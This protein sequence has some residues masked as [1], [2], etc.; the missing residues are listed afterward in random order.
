MHIG[1]I[2][3]GLMG[4][5]VAYYLAE[6][7][8]QVTVLEQG[9]ELGGLN[10]ELR[11]EDGLS[12]ARY[13]HSI[14]PIDRAV[15]N[16]CSSLGLQEELVFQNA[17]AGFVHDGQIH[18]M[19][20]ILDFL[21]FPMLGMLDRFRLGGMILRARSQANWRELDSLPVKEWLLRV[22]GQETFDR[23][24]RPLLEAK[25]DGVYDN[26]SATYIWAWLN[27]MSAIRR[28]P[29]LNGS[30]GYLR[31]GHFSLIHAL[32]EAFLRRSGEIVCNVRVR[33]IDVQDGRLGRVRT[34]TGT[35]EFDALVA[36]VATPTFAKML[37][38]AD[39]DYLGRMEK[40]KYLGLICPVMVLDKQLS[41]FWTLNLT[42]PTNPFSVIIETPHPE[43]PGH[44]VVY[45]PRYTA[46]DNDWMGVSDDEIRTAW[47]SHLKQI[48]P[49]FNESQ[50]RHFAVSRSRFVEPVH[51]VNTLVNEIGVKTPYQGLYLANTGQVYPELPT[52]EAVIIQAR[53]VA[54]TILNN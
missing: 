15:I 23:I 35:L 38:G 22:G 21:T 6:A 18:A 53:R 51:T 31:R 46:P 19:T 36:A 48:F 11:F 40:A 37:P 20:N 50:V 33:E 5:A 49:V 27:R 3:G 7:G 28:V 32:S 13:Q 4:V 45:L 16:L 9:E 17:H 30:V 14:L 34:H 25:F 24:W 47:L 2:G 12:V 10:G 1:V 26:V 52:S 42:D 39:T 29:R 44:H 41:P 43:R 8:Q 54:Q